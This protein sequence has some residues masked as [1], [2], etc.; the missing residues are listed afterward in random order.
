MLLLIF[1][2]ENAQPLW[3]RY[4]AISPDGNTIVF[5]Y[6]GDLYKVSSN[7]GIA[8][9]LTIHKAYDYKPVWSPD[10]KSIAFASNRYGNFDIFLIPSAGGEAKKLTFFSGGETPNSFTPDGENILYS[11][12]IYD[13]PNN[14]QFPSG[15]LSE[16]YSVPVNGERVKQVL[17]T[18][19]EDA[20]YNKSGT[21]IIYMDRK[22]YE[23]IWRKHH[24]SSVTRDIWMYDVA[25]GNH[26]KLTSFKG[27]DRS[28]VFGSD[29]NEIFYLSEQFGSF[30]VCKINLSAPDQVTQ[31]SGFEK[32][33]V[34]FLSIADNNL[35][36]YSFNGEI[37]TQRSDAD[38]EKVNIA[39]NL[40]FESSDVEFMKL[41]SGASEMDLSPNGKEIAFIVRGEVFV[42]S[43]DYGTTKRITN[44]PEQERSVSFGPD[45]RTLVY[46]SERNGSWNLY[47]SK[48]ERK[49]EKYFTTATV[50]KE[51]V[52]L[53]VPQETFQ[54]RFSPDG[55]EIA[56][57]EERTTLKV[58]NLESKKTRTILEGKYNYSYSDGDQWY[59]WSPDG[60][61]FLVS[62][63]PNNWIIN[64]VGLIKSDG[65][66]EVINLT[67]SGYSDNGPQWMMKG[68]ALLWFTDRNGLRSH[69]SWGAHYDAYAMFF[70]KKAFDRFKLS[71]EEF[72]VL[73]EN[74]KEKEKEKKKDKEPTKKKS[75]EK[76]SETKKD[77]PLVIELD[78]IEDRT[79][80]LTIHSS[81]LAYAI[82]SP[83]AD[84]LYYL[85]KFEKGH[86][87]WMHDL[88][89]NETKLVLKLEGRGG[90]MQVDTAFKN[91]YVFS[92]GNIVKIGID[93][94]KK[95]PVSYN[96][97]MNL[98]KTLER[99]YM[100][101][102]VWRQVKKK[103]YNPDLHGV[104][105]DF[106]KAEYIKF[107]PHIN[108]NFDF[109][110]MLS[111]MLGELNGSHTGSG[112]RFSDPHGDQTAKLGALFDDKFTGNGLKI[113]EIFDK[114]PLIQEGSKIKMGT[115]IEKIDGEVIATG[116]NYFKM[117]NHKAGKPTL[118]SLYDP[119]S[120]THWEE[121]IKPISI[122]QEYQLLY[123]R[124]VKNR[125]AET[126]KLSNGRLGYIHVRSMNSAS[127]RVAYSE[128]LGRNH[129]K[130]AIIV[131]TRF[132]GGGWL[133]DDL[134]TLLNGQRYADY[135][136]GGRYFGS[137]PIAK[138]DKPSIVLVSESN[139]S[140]AHAF[141]YAYRALNIGKIVGMPVP[142]T[143]TA[144]WWETLQDRSLYFGI[145]QVGTKDMKGEYLENQQL[146]PDYLVP[147]EYEVVITDRDQ[148]LEK[149]VEVLLDELDEGKQ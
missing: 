24:K 10:G 64:E 97:E 103:W 102:H 85:S 94:H 19:A 100:F 68:N 23:N 124:W 42:T 43:T 18:P 89:K 117:L 50:L 127:F 34:R 143:M 128:I 76:T 114:G 81:D 134:A 49:E 115:I 63:T 35:L 1:F 142:G 12:T 136:P 106:Y 57:L 55:K 113:V 125:R 149:A 21:K 71:K 121:T 2:K 147:N 54:P 30:N 141:P 41:N 111:E 146:E 123:E 112:Y 20:I 82:L 107:L 26:V 6:K 98:N 109:A 110:E 16:L 79:A 83:E 148:Q 40:D 101:E 3:M 78:K 7:G 118:L 139:Y 14:V 67:K 58:I 75:K 70:N 39:I 37:Y 51:E 5:S 32:H 87:L 105:W 15:V 4:P 13:N 69:G 140:D 132:N 145:P 44:T 74:D 131:D 48:I 11:A 53:E 133:H 86:D 90:Y 80:R 84:K 137:E 73:K 22:G 36:C 91:L 47:T 56:Y 135:Y 119:S 72:E 108:N 66:G 25:T 138:W 126:E 99:E 96:A 45:E 27:E 29:Q 59:Q 60:K 31:V 33:P 61:W 77:K 92:G 8:I 88:K 17:S 38:P 9:P 28:P 144:V 93:D 62:Y 46:A 95:K 120:N 65:S 122:G 52:V 129:E 104:D 130:E 116:K